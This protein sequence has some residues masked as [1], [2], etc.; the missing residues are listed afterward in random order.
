MGR[1]GEEVRLRLGQFV[2]VLAWD[3]DDL[4]STATFVHMVGLLGLVTSK[5]NEGKSEMKHPSDM[6]MPRFEN[7]RHGWKRYWCRRWGILN[8]TFQPSISRLEGQ[9]LLRLDKQKGNQGRGTFRIIIVWKG[10]SREDNKIPI[11]QYRL[12]IEQRL[13]CTNCGISS[14]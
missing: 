12:I 7:G 14:F 4:C 2:C 13:L 9:C 6:P 10:T 11:R 1:N 8:A 3:D 5:G